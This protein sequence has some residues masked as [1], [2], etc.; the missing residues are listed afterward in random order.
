MA[1][2]TY[3]TLLWTALEIVR[4]TT[5]TFNSV[6][7][8]ALNKSNSNVLSQE[9]LNQVSQLCV[10]CV[11]AYVCVCMSSWRQRHSTR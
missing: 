6:V 11:Y 4:P 7:S 9:A 2:T 5:N 1:F 8:A 10:F 3:G